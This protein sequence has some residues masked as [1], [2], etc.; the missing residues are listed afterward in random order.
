M[1]RMR[2]LVAVAGDES[3]MPGQVV[4]VDEATAV[5]WCDGERA[6]R[7]DE[8]KRPNQ[9]SVAEKADRPA[10]PAP[11]RGQEPVGEKAVQPPTGERRG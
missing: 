4:E 8:P 11:R 1:A 6:V 2:L 10:K 3:W 7:V 9:E 5:A